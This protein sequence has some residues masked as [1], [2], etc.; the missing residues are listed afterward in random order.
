MATLFDFS[1]ALS[2]LNKERRFGDTLKF[3]KDGKN[4]FTSEQI[5]LNKYIVFEMISA[6]IET[7]HYDVIFTFIEQYNVVLDPSNFSYLLKKFKDKPSVNWIVVDKFCDLVSVDSLNTECR[8]IEVERKGIKKPMELASNKEDWYA[9]K[10]KALFETQQYQDCFNF[11]K[12]ALESFDKFHY[13]NEIWFARRIALS[14]KNL[15]NSTE[16]LNELLLILRRKKEWFIQNEVAQI[17][18]ENGENDKAFDFA[19]SAINNFGDLEY[20]VG[21]IVLIAELLELKE[22][23][24]L[25]FKHY[26]LSKLLRQ[27]EGWNVPNSVT[28]VLSKFSFAQIPIEK[29]PDLTKELKSYWNS[30]KIQEPPFKQTSSKL[31]FGKISKILNNDERGIDGF[32]S[33]DANKSIY[34]RLSSESEIK[35]L[36]KVGIELEFKIIPAKDGKKERATSIN[37]K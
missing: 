13:S 33:Y 15:G 2:K 11:S 9:V 22:E 19:I 16:A 6:L 25:S 3:F 14:K 21:L 32:I 24:E 1:Q 12:K 26:S 27:N 34:F 18:K 30:F 17:Y 10:T 29:L 28:L 23:K 20:K 5:G 8:T 31:Q 37:I 7:N 4:E 36:L 35:N